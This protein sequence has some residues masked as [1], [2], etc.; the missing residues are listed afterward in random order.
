M[1]ETIQKTRGKN[2]VNKLFWRG[3][4]GVFLGA[5]GTEYQPGETRSRLCDSIGEEIAERQDARGMERPRAAR[6]S[7]H[8]DK[9]N[10]LDKG[11]AKKLQ[12]PRRVRREARSVDV[13]RGTEW[14]WEK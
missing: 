12:E 9:F 7:G 10:L 4:F 11:R 13:S 8:Y 14:R 2:L 5:G 3:G 6:R 1:I